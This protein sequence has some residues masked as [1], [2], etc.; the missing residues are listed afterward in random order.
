MTK[1]IIVRLDHLES[2]EEAFKDLSKQMTE[3]GQD[4]F[5]LDMLAIGVINR[6]LSLLTGFATLIRDNNY[7][8][9][10]HLTRPHLDNFLRFYASWLVDK[11]H[12]FAMD[13]MNG[14]RIDKL[15]DRDGKL[16]R[17]SHLVEVASKEYPWIQNVY[18]ET[19]GFI[20]LSKKHIFTSTAIKEKK[21]RTVEIRIGKKDKYITEESK[22]EAIE[23]MIEITNCII[24]LLEG[25]I[26]TKRN[27][28]KLDELKRMQS[29]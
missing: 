28:D 3:P 27:P 11:P 12:D 25:W 24:K 20:H 15:K 23:C 13:V 21:E 10:A 1:Q 22:V 2:F 6:S 7:I 19:S 4:L 16:L 17:D 26:W 14:V 9:A 8:A 29:G 18:K 5:P